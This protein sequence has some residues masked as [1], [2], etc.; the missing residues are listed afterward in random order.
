MSYNQV[1]WAARSSVDSQN[2]SRFSVDSC[3][4][5]STD[6]SFTIQAVADTL[7]LK[8]K[9]F[10]DMNVRIRK[11]ILRFAELDDA[12]RKQ[13]RQQMHQAMKIAEQV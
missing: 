9:S 2:R 4:R 13:V 8:M 7:N 11:Q 12:Q 1:D 6:D 5:P 3:M 10:S